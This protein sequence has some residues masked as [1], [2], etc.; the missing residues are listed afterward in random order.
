YDHAL[1][2]REIVRRHYAERRAEKSADRAIE[3]IRQHRDERLFVWV[4]FQDPHGPYAP[5]PDYRGLFREPDAEPKTLPLSSSLSGRGG[6]PNYQRL[7]GNRDYH[8]YVSQY[9][10]EIRYLDDHFDRLIR[11]IADLGLYDDAVIIFT[12]DHGEGM[13][14]H[15][16][17]FAHGE[18]LYTDL[19]HV[20]LIIRYGERS[21]RR[22][23]FVQHI[24]LVP[25]LRSILGLERD[26]RLRGRDLLA[27]E[28]GEPA[29]IF[30]EMDSPTVRD[31]VKTA[32]LYDGY[33]LIHTPRFDSFELY[34]LR[35][36]FHEKRNL[37]KDSEASPRAERMK[38]RLKA[39]SEE[40][41]LGLAIEGGEAT[42]TEAELETLRALGYAR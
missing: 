6:I 9:D 20:P 22:S 13:G 10:G 14:N 31:H 37:L 8:H 30:A 18:N 19:I 11:A 28:A 35:T 34:D 1:D 36:D 42:R 39:I 15:Q 17:Y 3:L 41:R 2:E 32:L 25:T 7:G 5:P 33:K 23:D 26:A 21:G 16:Y 4:H 38:A 24:D 12:A 29:E 27:G 40:D